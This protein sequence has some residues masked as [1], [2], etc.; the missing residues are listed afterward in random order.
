MKMIKIAVPS[1]M[2]MGLLSG[3]STMFNGKTQDVQFTSKPAGA[4]VTVGNQTCTTPCKLQLTKDKVYREIVVTKGGYQK[5]KMNIVATMEPWVYGNMLNFGI[6]GIV[7]LV[8][9]SYAK[10]EPEYL[11]QL[12]RK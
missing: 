4:E 6:G 11:V 8:M 3:C 5:E 2:I 12:E 9:G 1:I 10:Y 7:D